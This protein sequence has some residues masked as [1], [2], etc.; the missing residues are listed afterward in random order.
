MQQILYLRRLRD[1]GE[2]ISD[3]FL[4]LKRNWKK[5]IGV[6]AV[7][8]VPFL[9][10]A[11]IVGA[12]YADHLYSTSL[13]S[14]ESLR[15]SDILGPELFIIILC[16]LMAGSSYNVAV[17][18]YFRIYEEQKGEQPTIQQVGQLFVKKFFKAFLYNFLVTI[19]LAIV[20][21]LPAIGL[22]MIPVLGVVVIFFGFILGGLFAMVLL[23]Y[24][25]CVYVADDY[26][27]SGSISR[28]FYLLSNR[29]WNTIGFTIVVFLIYYVFSAVIQVV[30]MMVM[31][32]SSIGFLT[33]RTGQSG[34]SAHGMISLMAMLIGLMVLV[35]QVFYLVVFCGVGVNYYSLAEEKDGSAIE[36]QIDS[37]GGVSDK[38]GGIEEQ[39]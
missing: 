35:Q 27:L 6:Y 1:F 37:I 36:A 25:N 34:G 15:S 22:A 24:L 38:Y 31:G 32:I 21:I 23:F 11:T 39:Y 2:K 29:W 7:F 20:F 5:L 17:F 26:G 3:T 19:L 12:F 9:L 18:S 14:A 13:S 16:L 33:P 30:A 28:L 8:V 4:F 10:I